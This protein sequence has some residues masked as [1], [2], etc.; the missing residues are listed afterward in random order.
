MILYEGDFESEFA[1]EADLEKV[2]ER[3]RVTVGR[4]KADRFD[5]R[6]YWGVWFCGLFA[7]AVVGF[8][9]A[10]VFLG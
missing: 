1:S 2:V 9:G 4:R 6:V 5:R 8:L 7:G 3:R 10:L